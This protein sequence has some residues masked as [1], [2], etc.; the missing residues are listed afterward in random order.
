MEEEAAHGLFT[1]PLSTVMSTGP[2]GAATRAH[3]CGHHH[4]ELT[5]VPL[6]TPHKPGHLLLHRLNRLCKADA[7]YP[8]N[9]YSS[10]ETSHRPGNIL[11]GKHCNRE[12]K[13]STFAG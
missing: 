5:N 3:T 2:T 6:E 8:L 11:W 1:E 9:V 7:T 4:H 12:F 10:P 13:V